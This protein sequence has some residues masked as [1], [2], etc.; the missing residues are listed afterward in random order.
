VQ[1]RCEQLGLTPS[2]HDLDQIYRR[3]VALADVQKHVS[4]DDLL[5]I[6]AEVCGTVRIPALGST[7]DAAAWSERPSV[8]ATPAARRGAGVPA[9]QLVEAGYGFGV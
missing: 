4:E 6:T 8:S 5:A 7:T 3:I 2:R 9:D 1:K